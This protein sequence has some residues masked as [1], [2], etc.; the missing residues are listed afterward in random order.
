M[1]GN[2][3]E[4]IIKD[5]KH[6]I[7]LTIERHQY[8]IDNAMSYEDAKDKLVPGNWHYTCPLCH[9]AGMEKHRL[10]SYNACE[11]C[12]WMVITQGG[13]Y[14]YDNNAASIKR[15]KRWKLNYK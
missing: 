7:D 10:N 9:F 6:A 8:A 4:V 12:P 2:H 14:D 3:K 5:W 13:C 15:L 11:G 1:E